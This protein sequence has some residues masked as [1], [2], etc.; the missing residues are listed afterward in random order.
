[1]P[2]SSWREFNNALPPIPMKETHLVFLSQGLGY[3]LTKKTGTSYPNLTGQYGPENSCLNGVFT[4][5][6]PCQPWMGVIFQSKHC[7]I[8]AWQYWFRKGPKIYLHGLLA[9]WN[10]VSEQTNPNEALE[11]DFAKLWNDSAIAFLHTP[12]RLFNLIHQ[13]PVFFELTI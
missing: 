12:P 6:I 9:F 11:V 7:N 3:L 1:M 4:P 13:R 5:G 10:D 8:I 2:A